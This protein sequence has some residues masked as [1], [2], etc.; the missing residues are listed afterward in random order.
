MI[1]TG[2]GPGKGDQTMT[3]HFSL[4]H[5][6][7]KKEAA[8]TSSKSAAPILTEPIPTNLF[9]LVV[10][11]NF[12]IRKAMVEWLCAVFPS[13]R[14]LEADSGEEALRLFFENKPQIVLMDI[15]L[16]HMNGIE[17]AR[18]VKQAAPNT[19]VVMLT[20]HEDQE[21]MLDAQRAGA[22]GFV[23]KSRIF[24]DLLPLIK[25]LLAV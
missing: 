2:Q 20:V 17:T 25:K 23:P 11:D 6:G 10:E 18:Q 15:G 7:F 16:P 22:D 21:Y 9:L 8:E 24:K 5:S 12:T 3:R 13:Y 19:R 1:F 14:F 4:Q